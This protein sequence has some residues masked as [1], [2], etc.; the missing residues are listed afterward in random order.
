MKKAILLL[1]F[2]LA[3]SELA[4]AGIIE[5]HAITCNGNNDGALVLTPFGPNAMYQWQ[6]E[7]TNLGGGTQDNLQNCIA[8]EYSVIVYLDS[9][10]FGTYFYTLHEPSYSCVDIDA[11]VVVTGGVA[12]PGFVHTTTISV[13]N[14]SR[15]NYSLSGSLTFFADNRLTVISTFPPATFSGNVFSWNYANIPQ[16]TIENFTV[17]ATLASPPFVNYGDTLTYSAVILPAV[18]L[19]PSDSDYVATNNAFTAHVPVTGAMDP[20]DKLVSPEGFIYNERDSILLYTIRFQNTGTDTAFNVIIRDTLSSFLDA[21]S[22]N[23]VGASHPYSKHIE[24]DSILIFNFTNILLPDSNINEPGSKGFISF[25]SEIENNVPIES[26]IT[27]SA[28]IYFDFNLPVITNS[29]ANIFT[30][31]IYTNVDTGICQGAFYQLG[32]QLYSDANTYTDTLSSVSGKDSIVTLVLAINPLPQ[33]TVLENNNDLSTQIFSSYEWLLDDM[34][35][36]GAISQSYTAIESGNYSVFVTD[37]NNCSDTSASVSVL[38][39]GLEDYSSVEYSVII[40]PN[41][42]SFQTTI[43]FSA[44]QKNIAIKIIDLL[45]KEIKNISFSGKLLTIEK[46][47]MVAGIYFLQITDADKNVVNKKI[48]VQ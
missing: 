40:F 12:R 8:G 17:Y 14:W 13:K 26:E 22:I 4:Q 47:D 15:Q 41:P 34:T 38:F 45:G 5:T 9:N 6:F 20:N 28:A 23:V 31:P 43:S 11:G 46:E 36:N 37:D 7:G 3:I 33:P 10:Y 39:T 44:E 16:G 30:E 24:Q 2:F 27:N 18:P 1:I 32:S 48:V 42:F 19:L 25:Y 21:M 29:V 35:I